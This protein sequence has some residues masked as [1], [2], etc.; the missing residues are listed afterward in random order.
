[1]EISWTPGHSDIKGYELADRL[2]KEAAEEAKEMKDLSP[3]IT[4]GDIK[5]AARVSGKKKWKDMW[6]KSEIYR[7]L[8]NY[9]P[10]VDYKIRHKFD[11]RKGESAVAQLRTG[12]ARLNEYLNKRYIAESDMCQCREIESVIHYLIGCEMYEQGKGAAMEKV[13]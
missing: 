5:A 1:M 3:V 4:M 11:T 9:K 12:Y 13:V 2:A 8:F 10:Q 7:H 6:E